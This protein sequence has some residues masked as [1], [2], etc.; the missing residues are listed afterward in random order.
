VTRALLILGHGGH[1]RIVAD[2]ATESGYDKIAFLDDRVDRQ[3]DDPIIGPMTMVASLAADWPEAIAAIGNPAVRL[4][5]FEE[6]VAAGYATPNIVHPSAVVSRGASLGRGVFVGAGA[7]VNTG[8]RIG[9]AAIINTGARVDHDCRI[10]AG[11]HIAPGVSLSG[12]V[13]VG[14]NVWIG[15]GSSVR[16]DITIA[17]DIVIGVGAA[18]VSNLE[19]TG[20]YVGVP[21]R[22]M[23][24]RV[25]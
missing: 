16:Q 15:T 19:A 5:L 18:V 25:L 14:T 6:L 13:T 17:D 4:R 11:A 23:T 9:D 2:A 3:G 22:I 20:T 24:G 7:I 1:G 10:G 12:N 21:A 8:A